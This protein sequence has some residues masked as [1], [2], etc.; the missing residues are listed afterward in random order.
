MNNHKETR[1][2]IK[3][4]LEIKKENISK[5]NLFFYSLLGL[6]MGV[7]DS[8]PGVSS[9][10]ILLLSK[11]YE[12]LISVF[13]N[14]FSKNFV[15]RLH[16]F[17][18]KF[19]FLSKEKIIDFYKEFHL[20]VA[21]VIIIGITIGFLVSFFTVAHFLETYT[22]ITLQIIS[23]IMVFVSLF[24]VY[25]YKKVFL[26]KADR[27]YYIYTLVVIILLLVFLNS[28]DKYTM[29]SILIFMTAFISMITM[30]LPGISGSLILVLFGMYVPIKNALVEWD[31]VFLTIYFS[32][33]I[34]GT[35]VG[36]KGIDYL[37]KHY[38]IRMKFILLGILI[39]ATIYLLQ[40]FI[41]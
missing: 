8:I 36:L 41:F 30:L 20:G 31:A 40:N 35:V 2:K 23:I 34:L 1:N 11:K 18:V 37:N 13:A 33:S 27:I 17:V 3:E 22:K 25:E 12:F 19:E 39:A 29:S 24:Y 5:D 4:E 26:V 9:S 32:G 14:F 10:T 6:I 7:T 16:N 15:K 38:S 28:I 21:L